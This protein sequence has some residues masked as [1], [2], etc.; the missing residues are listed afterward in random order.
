MPMTEQLI[1]KIYK[2]TNDID[3]KVYIGSTRILPRKRWNQHK[4]EVRNGCEYPLHKHIQ[5]VGIAHFKFDVIKEIIVPDAKTAKIQE[6]IEIW[7]HDNVLNAIRSHIPTHNYC[8]DKKRA[9]RMAFYH[10]SKQDPEWADKEKERNRERMRKKREHTRDAENKR[11]AELRQQNKK[12]VTCIC[13]GMYNICK[14][15]DIHQHYRTKK[16][17][18]HVNLIYAKLRT[19]YLRFF[20]NFH[21]QFF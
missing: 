21:L 18:N 12:L 17:T 14:K 7:N 15:N 10:R 9:S 3:N 8:N 4:K 16:H 2:I 20:N 1:Y 19:L 13:G 5:M 6:Q 11:T